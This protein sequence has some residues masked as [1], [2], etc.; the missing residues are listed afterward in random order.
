MLFLILCEILH[1][2]N[3]NYSEQNTTMCIDYRMC[4]RAC[5]LHTVVVSYCDMCN[6]VYHFLQYIPQPFT[7]GML[8]T[9]S[10]I[11]PFDFYAI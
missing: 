6:C 10:F 7:I 4:N 5:M 2:K 9:P 3:N 11:V 1:G 8:I